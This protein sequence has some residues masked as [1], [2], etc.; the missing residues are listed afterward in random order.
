[1]Q[2]CTHDLR[3]VE[4]QEIAGIEQ[5]G[6]LAYPAIVELCRRPNDQQLCAVPGRDRS[7]RDTLLRQLEIERIDTHSPQPSS[8]RPK[9]GSS[10]HTKNASWIPAFAGMTI[11]E[12]NFASQRSPRVCR[13]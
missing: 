13:H 11:H 1:M 8:P 2:G 10:F 7:K 9:S 6:K 4:D 5:I 12:T 3:V